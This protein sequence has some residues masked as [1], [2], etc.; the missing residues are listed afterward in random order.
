MNLSHV[1]SLSDQ[2]QPLPQVTPVTTATPK[3]SPEKET[4]MLQQFTELTADEANHSELLE[5]F[6]TCKCSGLSPQAQLALLDKTKLL[7]F[8]TV[9]PWEV[10]E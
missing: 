8:H 1:L 7:L 2:W 5:L 3:F 6:L 4:V 10:T 9:D